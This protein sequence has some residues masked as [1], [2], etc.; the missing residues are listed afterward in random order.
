MTKKSVTKHSDEERHAFAEQFALA[1]L[2]LVLADA[3]EASGLTQRKLA[4]RLGV[5]E[6]RISQILAAD[7]NPTV[8]S[9]AR[10]A[11]ALG[12]KLKLQFASAQS[13][14]EQDIQ[15]AE[16]HEPNCHVF[17]AI[18][19]ATN[20]IPLRKFR[21]DLEWTPAEMPEVE[22]IMGAPYACVG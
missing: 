19:M 17:M 11:D 5:S 8:K 13:P 12:C 1:S 2:A 16:A 4:S 3:M 10:L 20:L 18:G 14:V 15:P 9:L 6:A 22:P 7:G 21:R